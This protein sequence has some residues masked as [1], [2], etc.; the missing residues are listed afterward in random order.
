[1]GALHS[2]KHGTS[3]AGSATKRVN[4][5]AGSLM[6]IRTLDKALRKS[7]IHVRRA[8]AAQRVMHTRSWCAPHDLQG[9]ASGAGG[10]GCNCAKAGGQAGRHI[11][12]ARP[13]QS[14]ALLSCTGRL[15]S[16]ESCADMIVRAAHGHSKRMLPC[17]CMQLPHTRTWH[18]AFTA[19]VPTLYSFYAACAFHRNNTESY[20]RGHKQV[21]SAG[22]WGQAHL[23]VSPSQAIIHAQPH[24]RVRDHA[25]QAR[26][27][28]LRTH[29]QKRLCADFGTT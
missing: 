29:G 20:G 19:R 25:Q 2:L 28:A 24:R 14:P 10:D 17:T 6:L 4:Y 8:A 1:M 21:Q 5:A 23:P 7:D 11:L 22:G 15:K 26:R 3:V 9:K 12:A 18:C 16:N 13:L 27:Q